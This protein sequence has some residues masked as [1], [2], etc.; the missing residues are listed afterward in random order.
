M[1]SRRFAELA[2]FAIGDIKTDEGEKVASLGLSG[3]FPHRSNGIPPPSIW[4]M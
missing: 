3:P 2:H 1:T 4:R